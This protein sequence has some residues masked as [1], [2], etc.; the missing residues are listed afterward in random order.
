MAIQCHKKG[1]TPAPG[2]EMRLMKERTAWARESLCLK[3]WV[4]VLA[5]VNQYPSHLTTWEG[6]KGCPSSSMKAVEWGL[7]W[8]GV[9][10][11]MS[12]PFG[13]EKDT[14]MPRPLVAIVDNSFCN[15]RIFPLQEGEATGSK[16]SST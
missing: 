4:V 7:L 3:W 2:E 16:R 12:L 9:R 1:M 15:W 6:W 11:L 5:G 14:P 8:L 13:T 10:Q